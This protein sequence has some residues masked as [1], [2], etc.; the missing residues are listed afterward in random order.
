MGKCPHHPAGLKAGLLAGLALGL[1]AG[2][3]TP[4]AANQAVPDAAPVT[5]APRAFNQVVQKHIDPQTEK[6]LLALVKDGKALKIDGVDVFN[7]NDKFL[8]GKIAIGLAEYLDALP[9]NDPRLTTYLGHFRKIAK[10]TVDDA[11]DSWGIYYYLTALDIL[12]RRGWLNQAID[13]LTMAKLRVRLDWRSFVDRDTYVLI[14]HPN[15]Y[16]VVAF[17]IARLRHA[18]GWEDDVA[19]GKLYDATAKHYRDYSAYGFADETDGEG[20]FDRYS[21]LLAGEIAARFVQTGDTPPKEALDWLRKSADLMLLRVNGEGVGFEYGRSIGPYGET[22]II[23][24]LTAAAATGVL[25]Q[26]EKDVAYAYA[27]RAAERY[28]DFWTDPRTGSVN[29]WDNGRR[30]DAYRGKFRILGENLS[31]AHQYS[32]TNAVWNKLGYKDRVP[33][34]DWAKV[35]TAKPRRDVT[36]FAR[37]DYDRLLVTMQDG[38]RLVSLPIINGGASQHDHSPYFPIPFS[39][40]MLEGVADGGAPLLVPQLILSDGSKLMPLAFQRGV[41]VTGKGKATKIVWHQSELD[42]MGE[43]APVADKR[44]SVETRYSFAPGRITRTDIF[45]PQAGV[46]ITEARM[47]FASFSDAAVQQGASTSFGQ[48]AVRRFTVSGMER[49]T[50]A[51]TGGKEAYRAPHGAM[52]SLVQCEGIAA[53]Q[54]AVRISW[55]LEYR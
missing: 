40:G 19:V 38:A 18:L 17:S 2:V 44:V 53:R 31:L 24:V 30:T 29:L 45:T 41:K 1:V 11:N 16:L 21:I 50:A 28:V 12:H 37:G 14:D 26:A 8:P 33:S 32:Y 36:W 23:E 49:C 51:P 22:S 4:V 15:N 43:R 48:G 35:Q 10:L 27:S 55:T 25:T 3:A 52:Q 7:S 46:T 42:R 47:E 13:P 5:T 54:G 6:L 39:P 20:R 9:A 34:V